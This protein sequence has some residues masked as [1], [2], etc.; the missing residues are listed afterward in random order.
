MKH[1]PI[2]II[3][4]NL[5][6]TLLTGHVIAKTTKK[7]KTISITGSLGAGKTSLINGFIQ[8]H[9]NKTQVKSPSFGLLNEYSTPKLKISHTDLYRLSATETSHFYKSLNSTAKKN[10]FIEWAIPELLTQKDIFYL[11]SFVHFQLQKDKRII[12]ILTKNR[13]S[14]LTITYIFIYYRYAE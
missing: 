4:Q 1:K 13:Y 14:L 8:F 12:T 5:E 3:S 7:E 10:I 2:I 11:S 9:C 6:Q